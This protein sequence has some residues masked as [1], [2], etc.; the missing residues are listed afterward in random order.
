MNK[1]SFF[2][3]GHPLFYPTDISF[4]QAAFR[5]A[6]EGVNSI[7][8]SNFIL[9]GVLPNGAGGT[10]AGFIVLNGEVMLVDAVATASV[11]TT[12]VW[13]PVEVVDP[14]I[15]AVVYG[16]GVSRECHIIRKARLEEQA[17]QP[18]R[19]L[20]SA[21]RRPY[22]F[23]RI[24]MQN[25]FTTANTIAPAITSHLN[26]V[27]VSGTIFL[28]NTSST[29]GAVWFATIPEGFR[30]TESKFFACYG[31]VYNATGRD[32]WRVRVDPDGKMYLL[33]VVTG[34]STID[35]NRDK[36]CLDTIIFSI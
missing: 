20:A 3:G 24:S 18:E 13:V 26:R 4:L 35:A 10:T 31:V 17:S 8:G 12:P 30:P 2:T 15:G 36:V 34:H 14:S 1:I 28:A 6:L 21:V 16:N 11:F 33:D 9:S 23:N 29:S 27:H 25:P 22:N 7:Y 5:Q 19:V 32:S